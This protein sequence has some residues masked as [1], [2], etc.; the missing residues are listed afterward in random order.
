MNRATQI[1]SFKATSNTTYIA[2]V[3]VVLSN[4]TRGCLIDN[5]S[6][7]PVDIAVDVT[8]D[9]VIKY[10]GNSKD[11]SVAEYPADK[12]SKDKPYPFWLNDDHDAVFDGEEHDFEVSGNEDWKNNEIGCKRNLEDFTRLWFFLGGLQATIEKGDVQVGF[13][14]K[15]VT[16]TPA[17]K[18]YE[19]VEY[20]GGRGYLT[21]DSD[22]GIQVSQSKAITFKNG[23]TNISGSGIYVF[24]KNFFAGFGSSLPAK[25]FV[26]EGS[27]N[28]KGQLVTVFLKAD[29]TEICEG[30]SVWLELRNIKEYYEHW[31]AGDTTEKGYKVASKA[32]Q[33]KD[34][35]FKYVILGDG[36]SLQG[37]E[38]F[39][40][41]VLFV[42]GWRMFPWERRA[43]AET[44]YK[45]MYHQGYK[46]KFGF[47]SWPTEWVDLDGEKWSQRRNAG[48]DP[49]NYDRSEVQARKPG[50]I[51][52]HGLLADLSNLYGSSHVN[53]FAHS[54]GNIV[55]SEALKA[56]PATPLINTYIACQSAEIAQC[57]DQSIL[58]T[59]AIYP[60]PNLYRYNPP[61]PRLIS[62]NNS[63][64]NYHKRLSARANN[65]FINFCNFSNLALDGWDKNQK[66]KPDDG[67]WPTDTAYYYVA[68]NSKTLNANSITDLYL[69][70]PPGTDT[71]NRKHKI[72][73]PTDRFTILAHI[74]SARSRA[75]GATKYL[76]GEFDKSEQVDLADPP[77]SFGG[78][79]YSHSSQFLSNFP[80]WR[81]F[82]HQ[83][84]I[85]FNLIPDP[86]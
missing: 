50:K 6:V 44:A 74:I 64:E 38:N 47:F 46:G 24:T 34:S 39:N 14:W 17:I 69:E 79:K 26:Y 63:G 28:G 15:N 83:L 62:Q 72:Y 65:Q 66:Y 31:T 53:V 4:T 9:G 61:S 11:I 58:D 25:Y 18:L 77:Y 43:F 1:A 21:N 8:R 49:Q 51:C 13:S 2:L 67:W 57:Y 23:R 22:A 80:A 84:M 10:A 42:H 40:D 73:W 30:P 56:H 60:A 3:P 81:A 48:W 16:G 76:G 32:T 55:V 19:S 52:L 7:T 37:S 68:K 75:T 5:N 27:G 36:L 71:A 33:P 54:M 45:R 78:G 82:Y 20:N 85:K 59:T 70:D 12:T 86:L 35:F 41:Y 29:G